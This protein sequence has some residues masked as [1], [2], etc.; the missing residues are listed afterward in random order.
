[1]VRSE[2]HNRRSM[3]SP[4]AQQEG[5]CPVKIREIRRS[6]REL[7]CYRQQEEKRSSL[8]IGFDGMLTF[9]RYRH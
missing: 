6:L 3:R 5:Q 4:G 2:S 9:N 8:A 1:M 7:P